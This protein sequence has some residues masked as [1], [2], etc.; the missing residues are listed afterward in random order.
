MEI[1]HGDTDKVQFGMGTFGSRSLAVG[2]VAIAKALDKVVTKATKIA[3]HQLE[4]STYP[5]ITKL[6]S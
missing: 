4:A 6:N 3:A 5:K 2:G 1:S